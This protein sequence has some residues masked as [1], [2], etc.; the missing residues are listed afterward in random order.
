[1]AKNKFQAFELEYC[2]SIWEQKVEINLTE[3][4][5]HP[6]TLSELIGDDSDLQEK[7]LALEI[8]HGSLLFFIKR[9]HCSG[10]KL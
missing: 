8:N 10:L 2:Q 6:V 1:M 4:G 3:S 5:V 7:L 9:M